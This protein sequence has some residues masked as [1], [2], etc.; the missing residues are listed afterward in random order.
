[1]CG[2]KCHGDNHTFE[3]KMKTL[4]LILV[5]TAAT[6][7]TDTARNDAS[8]ISVNISSSS[9]GYCDNSIGDVVTAVR[10]AVG[11]VCVGSCGGGLDL[12]EVVPGC[13]LDKECVKVKPHPASSSSKR[14]KADNIKSTSGDKEADADDAHLFQLQIDDSKIS[15]LTL[16]VLKKQ[17]LSLILERLGDGT[18]SVSLVCH[19]EEVNAKEGQEGH[20]SSSSTSAESSSSS[21]ALPPLEL[22]QWICLILLCSSPIFDRFVSITLP[23][24][25]NHHIANNDA[26]V[27]S[28]AEPPVDLEEHDIS[29]L[30]TGYYQLQMN[31]DIS[32]A[33]EEALVSEVLDD[34]LAETGWMLSPVSILYLSETLAV[35]C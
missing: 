20:S 35:L 18:Q 32:R 33:D 17:V 26:A 25:D 6:T 8:N 19:V 1:M 10:S 15:Q 2:Y 9:G 27:V 24:N 29:D 30:I 21:L 34:I 31:P 7:T 12:I 16:A 28:A 22:A 3:L 4:A 14:R 13:P 23:P 5:P 11:V